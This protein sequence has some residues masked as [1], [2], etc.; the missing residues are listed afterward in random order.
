MFAQSQ[1]AIGGARGRPCRNRQA[2]RTAS[3]DRRRA[4]ACRAVEALARKD[5]PHPRP[6]P[7]RVESDNRA[8]RAYLRG[9]D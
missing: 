1:I 3:D 6:V 4:A 8:I 5:D 9:H 7:E 2:D